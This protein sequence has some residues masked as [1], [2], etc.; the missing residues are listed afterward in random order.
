MARV[1]SY[2]SARV[3]CWRKNSV[4]ERSTRLSEI[5]RTASGMAAHGVACSA[6]RNTSPSATLIAAL[7]SEGNPDRMPS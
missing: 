4:N 3:R 6:I 5:T 7:T 1:S 2:T